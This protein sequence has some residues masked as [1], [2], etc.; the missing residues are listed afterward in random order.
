MADDN[1]VWVQLATRIPKPLHRRLKLHCVGA[2]VSVM[3]YAIT[4]IT[5]NL[6]R[7]EPQTASKPRPKSK[8]RAG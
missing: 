4:A 3:Q 6:D 1:A 2:N 7:D 5:A 8:R